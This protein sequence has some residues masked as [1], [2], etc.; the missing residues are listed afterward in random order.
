MRCSQYNNDWLSSL[1]QQEMEG[2]RWASRWDFILS[3]VPQSNVQWFS[4]INSILITVFLSAM[5]GMILLR[6]LH[7]D[8]ARYNQA[9]TSVST[10]HVM[11]INYA[12]TRN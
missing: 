2:I 6:S 12:C 7:R 4:L 8:I 10:D 5:V 11:V 9:E 1:T 3:S